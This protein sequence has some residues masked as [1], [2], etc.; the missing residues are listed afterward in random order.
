[1]ASKCSSEIKSY[2]SLT[3]NEKIHMIMLGKEIVSK[4][5]IGRAR[6]LEP[7]SQVVNAKEKFLKRKQN[8]LIAETQ[9]VLLVWIDQTSHNILLTQN[10]A[11]TLFNSIKAERGE[12]DT[13]E[14]LEGSRYWFMRFKKRSHLYNVK[15]QGEEASANAEGAAT[16]PEDLAKIMEGSAKQHIFNV[17]E[18]EEDIKTFTARGKKSMLSFKSRLTLLIGANAADNFK[19]NP[20]FTDHFENQR[21]LKNYAKSTLPVLYK[22]NNKA[23]LTAQYFKPT[24]DTYYSESVSHHIQPIPFKILLLIGNVPGHRRALMEMY[25]QINVV[26]MSADTIAILQPVDQEVILTFKSYYFRNTLHKAKAAI[27]SDSSNRSQLKISW[28]GFIILGAIKNI[29]DSLEGIKISK[30]KLIPTLIDD[31]EKW[32]LKMGLNCCNLMVKQTDK[33]LFFMMS[34]ECTFLRI[35][36]DFVETTTKSLEY[37]INLVDKAVTGLER[38]DSN[39]ER[40]STV[41]KLSNSITCYREIIHEKKSQS[42]WQTSFLSTQSSAT[43][44][45][46]SQQQ[47]MYRQDTPQAK[48]LPFTEG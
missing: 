22:W 30:K 43:T 15:V 31:T 45:L 3:L 14:K 36:C 47:F 21:A 4:T 39:F 26:F 34:K 1:M 29:H 11:L 32:S 42:M 23:Q 20:I 44:T 27:D 12:E 10:M 8:S 33:E 25:K 37:Y 38:T 17:D 28:K 40:S 7:N 19:L 46:I 5:K 24:V 2:M 35:C 13:E 9:K 6:P 41:G 48:T 18:M 16:Y